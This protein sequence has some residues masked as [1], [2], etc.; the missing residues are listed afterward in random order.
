MKLY[1]YFRSSA[2][3]RV[4]IALNLKGLDWE[5]IP[6]NLLK[7]EES[8]SPYRAVNPQGVVPSLEDGGRILTQSMA[9]IEYLEEKYPEPALLSDDLLQRAKIRAIAN[10]IACDIHPLN[11][12]KILKYLV[13]EL[14]VTE[15]QKLAWYGLWVQEGF[16]AIETLIR[17]NA[18]G[19]YCFGDAPT[20]AD[21]T[22]IPQVYNAN[23]FKV[24]LTEFPLIRGI[25]DHCLS[26]PAFAAAVP[27]NQIDA[28]QPP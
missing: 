13:S 3:Y 10:I 4:R 2:A 9:I 14:S 26:L 15:E 7:G 12:S 5:T 16:Q 1:S 8:A 24:D 6:V 11:N 20:L 25:N 22:L 28:P 18:N 21:V 17:E 27:E 23:R 19:R